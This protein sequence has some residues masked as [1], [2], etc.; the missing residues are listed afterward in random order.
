MILPL[1]RVQYLINHAA[2]CFSPSKGGTL[3][4]YVMEK[5][6]LTT[7]TTE[8][9]YQWVSTLGTGTSGCQ[10]WALAPAG[11]DLGHWHQ[12]VLNSGTRTSRCQP[13]A[14]VLAEVNLG[15]WYQRV[16]TLGTGT[17]RY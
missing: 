13:R 1:Y 5:D 16:S 6:S 17:S 9:W 2:C 15:H 8:H 3:S 7:C 4:K 10:L 14:L 12:Q 11:V